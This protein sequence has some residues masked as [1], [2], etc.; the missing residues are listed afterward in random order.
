MKIE[1][2]TSPSKEDAKAISPGLVNFN[3]KANRTLKR[4]EE[5]IMF[6]IFVRDDSGNIKGG[7][8][9]VCFWNVL[10]IELLWVSEEI[11]GKGLGSEL[12]EKA[13]LYTV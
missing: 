4:D 1:A 12:M 7:V 10:H 11:R 2:T 13:E 5:E 6:F 3:H 9:A 8:R